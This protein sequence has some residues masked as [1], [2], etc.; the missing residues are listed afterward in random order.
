MP[1]TRVAPTPVS[2]RI[3]PVMI[4]FTVSCA[5]CCSN[6]PGVP[7]PGDARAAGRGPEDF[8]RRSGL[9]ASVD[10]GLDD[11]RG[12]VGLMFPD[13]VGERIDP[14]V[15][16]E[17]EVAGGAD[18]VDLL[19]AEHGFDGVVDLLEIVPRAGI[20]GDRDD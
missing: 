4:P 7:R 17:V 11:L 5:S 8:R 3:V 12:T 15:V 18:K 6:V 13:V 16:R 9:L 20:V 2:A 1:K 14:P 19:A 10:D